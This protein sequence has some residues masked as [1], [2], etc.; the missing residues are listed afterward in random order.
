VWRS[1]A[2]ELSTTRRLIAGFLGGPRTWDSR[3]RFLRCNPAGFDIGSDRSDWGDWFDE[4]TVHF[5]KIKFIVGRGACGD[6]G[7][8]EH[9]LAFRVGSGSGGSTAGRQRA[10]NGECLDQTE[11]RA[12]CHPAL[13]PVLLLS[14]FGK[15]PVEVDHDFRAI[16]DVPAYRLL[17]PGSPSSAN[18]S[19]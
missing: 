16:L 7:E 2:E 11:P 3:S 8:G 10:A 15:I 6:V 9:F 13:T 14:E 12:H 18:C 19:Q 4:S 17:G 1:H 5:I